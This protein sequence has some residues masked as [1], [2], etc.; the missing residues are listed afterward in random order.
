MSAVEQ[1]PEAT[2]SQ[3]PAAQRYTL[4]A[5]AYTAPVEGLFISVP[6]PI[7]DKAVQLMTSPATNCHVIMNS[8]IN[9]TESAEG[10]GAIKGYPS[11]LGNKLSP[12]I[13]IYF[14]NVL[15]LKTIGAG[16]TRKREFYTKGDSMIE[17][18]SPVSVPAVMPQDTGLAE[19]F[20]ILRG[21]KTPT[22]K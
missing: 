9:Y 20:K 22:A 1:E 12:K 6:N 7:D 10:A 11:A 5:R 13:P 18:K 8:H 17:G 14:E 16:A 3:A 4:P 2:E 21:G 15:F 19:F